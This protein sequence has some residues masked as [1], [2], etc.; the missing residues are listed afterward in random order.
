MAKEEKKGFWAS[1][2][3]GKKSNDCC[4]CSPES[5]IE[6]VPEGESCGCGCDDGKKEESCCCGEGKKEEGTCCCNASG[7]KAKEVKILGPGCAKC[8]STYE[9]VNKVIR[10]NNLDVKVTKIEDI[11]EIMIYNVMGT[12]A[13]IVD[14]VVKIK[15]HVPSEEEVKK[16]LGL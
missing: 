3:G 9:V 2:F 10:E 16:A 8:K 6:E 1:L 14:G 11:V 4:C 5:M 12:P 15:N 13:L 7:D